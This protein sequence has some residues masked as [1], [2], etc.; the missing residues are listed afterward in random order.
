MA[1][2]GQLLAQLPHQPLRVHDPGQVAVGHGL[3]L[4]G[5]PPSATFFSIVSRHDR[6]VLRSSLGISARSADAASATMFSS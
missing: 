3:T 4:H 1:F 6:S 2:G 5:V